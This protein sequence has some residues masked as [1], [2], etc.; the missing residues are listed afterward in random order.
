MSKTWA[1]LYTKDQRIE[2]ERRRQERIA[3]DI[4]AA[5]GLEFY[6]G[7][8][9]VMIEGR[10]RLIPTLH[11]GEKDMEHRATLLNRWLLALCIV[12]PPLAVI[13]WLGGFDSALHNLT[14]GQVSE[15]EGKRVA[16]WWGIFGCTVI[17]VMI[18][19]FVP[20][21]ISRSHQGS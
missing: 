8:S 3:T 16:L 5:G 9:T 1:G 11:P 21:G 7:G 2:H 10:P 13:H 20:L 18:A 17:V 4:E 14:H 12:L 15:V 19:V 6:K